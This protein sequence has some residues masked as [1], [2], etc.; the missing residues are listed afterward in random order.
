MKLIDWKW[1]LVDDDKND[2]NDD[3]VQLAQCV[4]QYLIISKQI[5]WLCIWEA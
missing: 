4:S 2:D 1:C 3:I 5:F